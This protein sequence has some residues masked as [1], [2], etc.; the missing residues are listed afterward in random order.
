MGLAAA[1]RFNARAAESPTAIG[2]GEYPLD[3]IGNTSRHIGI[4]CAVTIVSI[5]TYV[6]FSVV[7]RKL[8]ADFPRPAY[9]YCHIGEP[10][11]LGR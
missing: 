2:G 8:D 9:K 3:L 1:H 6:A 5:R 10:L 7:A 11:A 4:A